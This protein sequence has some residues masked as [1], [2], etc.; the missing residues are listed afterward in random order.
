[1]NDRD[2]SRVLTG[3]SVV[4]SIADGN[5]PLGA[6]DFTPIQDARDYANSLLAELSSVPPL[7]RMLRRAGINMRKM[8]DSDRQGLAGVEGEGW[9]WYGE[10][11]T[12][13]HEVRT[14]QLELIS[15][16]TADTVILSLPPTP[17]VPAWTER[18]Q[19]DAQFQGWGL[20]ENDDG[21]WRVQRHDEG[22]VF[23]SDE[24]ARAYV[25]TAARTAGP[26]SIYA[27]AM[28]LDGTQRF[29]EQ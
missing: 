12:I 13:V 5:E 6:E 11:V 10:Q 15:P 8:L 18:D 9:V 23:P 21:E 2:M 19:A 24:V 20:F 16:D 17:A 29:G 22:D 26:G 7:V 28:T 25:A 3:L 1:M 14:G 4:R 27:R